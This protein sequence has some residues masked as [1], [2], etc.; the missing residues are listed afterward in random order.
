[1]VRL[2][3]VSKRLGK[4]QLDQ[5]SFEIPTGYICGLVGQN[6]AGKTSLLHLIL[7]LYRPDG[8]SVE[9]AGRTYEE[10]KDEILD[11]IGKLSV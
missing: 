1:M 9:I 7:G 11:G 5:L 2:D 3:N 8:G 6:G 10:K 4:F